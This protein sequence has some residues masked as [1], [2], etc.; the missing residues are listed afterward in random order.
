MSNIAIKAENLSKAYQLGEIGTGTIS[1]DLERWY[2]RIRGKEDPFLRI[3]E[4]N[5][6]TSKGASDVVWSLKDINFEIERGDAVGII[7]RNGAGKST[8]LKVLS[9]V[10][11]P[12]S[13]RITGKGR[14]ASL[15]EV[16]TG[17]HPELTGRE[18]IYLNGAILGMRKKEITRKFDEIVDFAGVERYIDTPVK[19]YS[20]GMY[21]RLAFA[22]AAH[23]ES[24][25]LI[26]D[27]V[28][29]VGDAEF[30]K[31][32]LGKMGEVSKGEGRTV[33][34]VS[35]NMGSVYKLCKKSMILNF[36]KL[37]NIGD[38]S[39]II[40]EYLQLQNENEITKS[41]LD[42]NYV[43]EELCFSN[44]QLHSLED[45]QLNIRIRSS[46]ERTIFSLTP[47]I[48]NEFNQRVAIIDLRNDLGSSVRIASDGALNIKI[49][50]KDCPLIEGKYQLGF[51]L[52]DNI[53]SKNILGVYNFEILS[54]INNDNDLTFEYDPS[55]RGLMNL[56]TK[57]I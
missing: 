25:I 52:Q 35:H 42:D 21:V 3:G 48:Y 14:I 30:Q 32:C 34:F 19:R 43:I 24:E 37:T 51:Y 7:G 54:A 18:N 38:T 44:T 49:A 6:R 47:L 55:V 4:T 2:A 45:I 9:R 16:G 22:V 31:K 57:I 36:G 11:S 8:L 28:L 50:I 27:E 56:Q 12:T 13:G 29:A 10:T 1:R 20:S 40:P 26:V 5:D 39:S 33:L 53:I 41:T 46:E 23:L 17:F 15:L